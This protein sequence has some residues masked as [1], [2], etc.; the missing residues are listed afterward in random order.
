MSDEKQTTE[1]TESES[2]ITNYVN[3]VYVYGEI[4]S[5]FPQLRTYL[6]HLRI[7]TEST[8][9]D[10]IGLAHALQV[11][12]SYSREPKVDY[13]LY[14]LKEVVGEGMHAVAAT[15][16]V[17]DHHVT[18]PEQ[19]WLIAQG[20]ATYILNI[21]A[22]VPDFSQNQSTMTKWRVEN[23]AIALLLPNT[24]VEYT[25]G[26]AMDIEHDLLVQAAKYNEGRVI[27]DAVKLGIVDAA[28]ARLANVPEWLMHERINRV[29]DGE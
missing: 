10:T 1:A 28:A 14:R 25:V 16:V 18:Y 27:F 20:L 13:S 2:S 11:R 17:R 7:P 23:L 6:Q 15:L 21:A 8:F 19:A 12:I 4:V 29:F 26:I 22:Y 3:A 5:D 24:L 9:T